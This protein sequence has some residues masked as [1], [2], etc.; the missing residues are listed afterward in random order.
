MSIKVKDCL[1]GQIR[2]PQ[3]A[4]NM[5]DMVSAFITKRQV[6]T[7][8]NSTGMNP[9]WQDVPEGSIHLSY[10]AMLLESTLT[11]EGQSNFELDDWSSRDAYIAKALGQWYHIAHLMNLPDALDYDYTIF[12]QTDTVLARML[13]V[14]F[15]SSLVPSVN[16]LTSVVYG[17]GKIKPVTN[18]PVII[19]GSKPFYPA[20]PA[21]I[22][23]PSHL[24][25]INREGI[26]RL[27]H[28]FY[29][30]MEN[31][32]D[33]YQRTIG[34]NTQQVVGQPGNLLARV[35]IKNDLEIV[36]TDLDPIIQFYRPPD[37]S[38]YSSIERIGF[39]R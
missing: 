33:R 8:D 7:W 32:I 25:I 24:W 27:R 9:L 22:Q 39:M 13:P 2:L 19:A 14:Y 10:E 17:S 15:E 20:Y 37:A 26:K 35:A 18:I 4:Y 34:F 38:D 36:G 3:V 1:F 21:L 23:I 12:R 11:P 6:V 5:S 30:D 28:V 29:Q 16:R 31:E